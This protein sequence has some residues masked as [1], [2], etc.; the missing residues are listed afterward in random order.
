M[1]TRRRFL[2]FLGSGA[3][4]TAAAATGVVVFKGDEKASDGLPV[5][6]YGAESCAGC[7][8]IIDEVRFAAARSGPGKASKHFDDIGCCAMDAANGIAGEEVRFFVHDYTDESWL[9]GLAASYVLAESIRSPMAYGLAA[10]R[11]EQTAQR[12]A[13]ETGGRV[14]S[15][16]ELPEHLPKRH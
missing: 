9:D 8:M 4:I 14:Y 3:A 1:P 12:L 15:W 5:I 6:R 13:G 10:V 2:A 16:A 7:G 11:D